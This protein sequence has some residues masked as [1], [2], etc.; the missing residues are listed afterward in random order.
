MSSGRIGPL[1][2]FVHSALSLATLTASVQI[3]F[4]IKLRR[5]EFYCDFLDRPAPPR[6]DPDGY[7]QRLHGLIGWA[8][9]RRSCGLSSKLKNRVTSLGRVEWPNVGGLQAAKAAG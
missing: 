1:I 2:C 7:R 6:A 9:G 5:L 4:A 3:G 8:V